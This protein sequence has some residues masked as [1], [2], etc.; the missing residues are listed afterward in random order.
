[1]FTLA[2]STGSPVCCAEGTTQQPHVGCVPPGTSSAPRCCRQPAT[3][4]QECHLLLLLC[5][6]GSVCTCVGPFYRS[7]PQKDV[8]ANARDG[9]PRPHQRRAVEAKMELVTGAQ[10][11]KCLATWGACHLSCLTVCSAVKGNKEKENR[12]HSK[13]SQR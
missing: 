2:Q 1:M 11:S 7:S 4:C 3:W 6:D 8:S 13:Y 10:K 9:E 5:Q 12:Q